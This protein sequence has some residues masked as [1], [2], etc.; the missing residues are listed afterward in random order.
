MC[1]AR[2]ES[3]PS[4]QALRRD[5]TRIWS[6]FGGGWSRLDA[7][8]T[9]RPDLTLLLALLGR[10]ASGEGKAERWRRG[11]A[12]RIRARPTVC[13][14]VSSSNFALDPGSVRALRLGTYR[15]GR[16]LVFRRDWQRLAFAPG[17]SGQR[18][19]TNNTTNAREAV[20]M[21]RTN[22]AA[23][24]EGG[25][26]NRRA[27]SRNAHQFSACRQRA[28]AGGPVRYP[29]YVAP[30]E[31]NTLPCTT[32]RPP[33]AIAAD[34]AACRRRSLSVQ[35]LDAAK[36]MNRKAYALARTPDAP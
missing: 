9:R 8:G 31:A 28:A 18:R 27:K 23:G 25:G 10:W 29:R 22:T 34:V 24:S 21:P 3:C 19:K 11:H 20:S 14:T 12:G 30:L 16:G 4:R 1:S 6:L 33:I 17:K 7:P 32:Q 26:L 13:N 2:Y 15:G 35:Q 5:V 36:G